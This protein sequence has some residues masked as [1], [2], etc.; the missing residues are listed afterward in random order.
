VGVGV[1]AG[2]GAGAPVAVAAG[3]DGCVFIPGMWCDGRVDPG[4]VSKAVL[5]NAAAEVAMAA[6]VAAVDPGGLYTAPLL[7]Q[8]PVPPVLPLRN[9]DM[10]IVTRFKTRSDAALRA[11]FETMLVFRNGGPSAAK[12]MAAM[13]ARAFAASGQHLVQGLAA[14]H[15]GGLTHNDIRPLNMVVSPADGLGRFIDFGRSTNK[16]FTDFVGPI[17]HL[18]RQTVMGIPDLTALY[19]L[20]AGGSGPRHSALALE[21]FRRDYAAWYLATRSLLAQDFPGTA[22]LPVLHPRN[23]AK[24]REL[25]AA[26]ALWD[27]TGAWNTSSVGSILPQYDVYCL[28]MSLRT[29][30]NKIRPA[31]GRGGP[32]WQ[33]LMAVTTSMTEPNLFL[34]PTAARAADLWGRAVAAHVGP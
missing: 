29:L 6:R 7:D 12:A 23:D 3:A 8:C 17:R 11:Q 22:P 2:A 26:W 10:D 15:A 20:R 13:S 18:F 27:P 33:A 16:G 31:A 19:A 34:R 9:C 25:M 21:T 5:Y 14:L 32:L 24:I 30:L 28:G 1:G 4:V